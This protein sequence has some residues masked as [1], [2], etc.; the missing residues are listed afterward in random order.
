MGMNGFGE[1][2]GTGGHLD[3]QG[4]FSDQLPRPGADD[5]HPEDGVGAALVFPV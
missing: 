3:G 4:S 5:P 2:A 1:V